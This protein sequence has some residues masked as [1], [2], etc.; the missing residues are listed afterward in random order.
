MKTGTQIYQ[1]PEIYK[2]GWQSYIPEKVDIFNL[3][4]I[5]FIIKFLRTP[6]GTATP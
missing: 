2:I 1:A 6:F 5:L 4:V 3:G